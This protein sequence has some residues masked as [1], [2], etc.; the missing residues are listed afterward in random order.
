MKNFYFSLFFLYPLLVVSQ[1]NLSGNIYDKSSKEPL[2]GASVFVDDKFITNTNLEGEYDILIEDKTKYKIE[3]SFVGYKTI[4]KE[5]FPL[6]NY[7]KTDF[8]LFNKTLNEI[9][10]VADLAIDRKTPVAFSSINLE[11][12]SLVKSSFFL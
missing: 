1:T 12:S 4:K 2:I 11:M 3:V 10:V 9:S 8:Y 6:N 7:L 5:L